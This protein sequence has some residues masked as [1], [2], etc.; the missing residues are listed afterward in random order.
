ML[1]SSLR[2]YPVPKCLVKDVNYVIRIVQMEQGTPD[3]LFLRAGVAAVSSSNRL[4][5]LFLQSLL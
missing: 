3:V 5:E 4:R 2:R 1:E